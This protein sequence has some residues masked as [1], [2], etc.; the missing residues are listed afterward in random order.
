MYDDEARR[1]AADDVQLANALE[2]VF[3]CLTP[4]KP[5]FS[6]S[7]VVFV[8][9]TPHIDFCCYSRSLAS[10]LALTTRRKRHQPQRGPSWQFKPEIRNTLDLVELEILS[11]LIFTLTEY[12]IHSPYYHSTFHVFISV[13]HVRNLC[14]WVTSIQMKPVAM[15]YPLICNSIKIC[16]FTY[17]YPN[18]FVTS[19]Y[20][21]YIFKYLK[22]I[23][24]RTAINVFCWE[25][26]AYR[27]FSKTPLFKHFK[28]K[29][30][31]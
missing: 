28:L 13:N 2:S 11:S 8:C 25:K 17:W 12:P 21:K 22:S 19:V 30:K 15:H 26:E 31:I 3:C 29:R 18:T 4:L 5:T 27:C 14:T 10:L 24:N 1:G 6:H 16:V 9:R 20:M 23:L 7:S